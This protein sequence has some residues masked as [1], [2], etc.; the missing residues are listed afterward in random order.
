[1]SIAPGESLNARDVAAPAPESGP[2]WRRRA[3]IAGVCMAAGAGLT[4][5]L[6][7][8][9]KLASRI[10]PIDLAEAL[11]LR[12]GDWRVDP[13]MIPV[14]PSADVQANLDKTYDQ[15]VSRT[16]VASAGQRVMVSVAYGSTQNQ[17]L[18][19]HRQEVCYSAQG[20]QIR[21]LERTSFNLAGREV[22]GTRFVATVGNGQRIEPVTYWFTMGDTVVRGYLDRQLT[23]LKYSMSGTI[24][25]GYLFRLSTLGADTQAAYAAHLRFASEL[26]AAMD[27]KLAARLVGSG[28][29][30]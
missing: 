19:A 1:M 20:F 8:T 7:P 16:Y 30:A 28:A 17:Q 13:T 10:A 2:D 3:V 24:P 27:S 11:P 23:Q 12:F 4:K 5:Y 22:E 26:L 14:V 25:D 6:T 29:P 18:R 21:G 9:D 15:I